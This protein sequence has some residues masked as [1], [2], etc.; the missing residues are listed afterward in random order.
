MQLKL[1]NIRSRGL[2]EEKVGNCHN[3]HRKN[4]LSTSHREAQC[5]TESR[6]KQESKGLS[7]RP[8]NVR[9]CFSK[10]SKTSQ[11]Q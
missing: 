6:K 11:Q 8:E 2:D 9:C 7:R 3:V 4:E 1:W 5:D 10:N